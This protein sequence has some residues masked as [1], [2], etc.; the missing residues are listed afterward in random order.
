MAITDYAAYK[1]DVTSPRLTIHNTKSS[2]TTAAGR[3]Y[4]SWLSAPF[5]GAAPTTAAVPTNSTTGALNEFVNSSGTQRL[6]GA[7]VAASAP[8]AIVLCDRLSHQGGL[9]GIVAT[10]QTTN[11]ATAALTRYTSGV[12][13]M[14]ALEIYTQIGATGT[15]VTAS[16]TNSAP[17]GGRTTLATTFGGTGFREASRMILLPLQQGDDGVRSVESVTVLATTGTAGAFGVTLFKPLAVLP[18]PL[19]G[20]QWSF[21]SLFNMGGNAPQIV[22]NSCLFFM[23]IC[24]T[25]ATGV[26]QTSLALAED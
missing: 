15:T 8:L 7:E 16:Y 14:A 18:V 23:I 5:A 22:D 10:A 3:T 2:I 12:G 9:S 24:N 1:V 26:L 21:N 19:M 25:T 13:V 11:L 17:T 20:Q 6:L 4:S